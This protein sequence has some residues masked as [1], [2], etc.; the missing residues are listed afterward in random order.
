MERYLPDGRVPANQLVDI[1]PLRLSRF[2]IR[3]WQG[4]RPL[5]L[6]YLQNMEP[7]TRDL[8]QEVGPE[9]SYLMARLIEA[10]REQGASVGKDDVVKGIGYGVGGWSGL[11]ASG[12]MSVSNINALLQ[13]MAAD[14][15]NKFG[16]KMATSKKAAHLAKMAQFFKSH[17]NYSKVMQQVHKLP[18][19]LLPGPR[20]KILPPAAANVDAKALA[21]YFRKGYYQSFRRLS[22]GRYMGPIVKQLNGRIGMFKALG[23]HA[24]WYVP[25][26]IGMYNVYDAPP[27]ERMRTL[28][29][30]GFGVVGGALG[31]KAGV[32]VGLGIVAILGLGPFGLFLMVFVC[33]SLGGIAGN[34]LFKFGGG[35]IYDAGAE[36]GDRIFLSSDELVG[37]FY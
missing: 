33:A 11:A 12:S 37:A 31:T 10:L 26:V 22:S 28:F 5:Y 27:E 32:A 34:E 7:M 29:S 6:S 4:E 36:L 24:T 21:R 8:F 30:E 14:A 2:D 1:T 3:Y 25:A 17:P 18:D 13:Q 16:P 35:K 23:R 9:D 15:V 20:S 19:V